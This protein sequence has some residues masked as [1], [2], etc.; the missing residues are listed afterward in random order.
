MREEVQRWNGLN[1]KKVNII[2]TIQCE[3]IL[4][5]VRHKRDDVVGDT[6]DNRMEKKENVSSKNI[7]SSI[8]LTKKTRFSEEKGK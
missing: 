4:F 7:F 8:I 1:T 5:C 2:F 3:Y 6:D